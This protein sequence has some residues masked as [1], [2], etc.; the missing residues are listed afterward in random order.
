M[1]DIKGYEGRYSIDTQGTIYSHK[2]NKTRILKPMLWSSGYLYV[3]FYPKGKQ[4]PHSIHRLVAKTFLP[5]WDESLEVN[6]INGVK[7]DNRLCNLEM[8]TK[9]ENALHAH[10]IGLRVARDMQG[11]KHP[12]HKLT[13]SDINSIKNLLDSNAMYHWEIAAMYGVS[14]SLISSISRGESWK[15][16]K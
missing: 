10:K 16:L 1:R 7:T 13:D 9:A 11:E 15:H 12:S 6:H 3:N 8:V 5:T 2:N 14:R 4:K